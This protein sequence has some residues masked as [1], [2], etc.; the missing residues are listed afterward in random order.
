MRERLKDTRAQEG[1]YTTDRPV[2]LLTLVFRDES[3]KKEFCAAQGLAES[4]T[5]IH[6]E[7]ILDL[8]DLTP[9]QTEAP[10]L[11]IPMFPSELAMWERLKRK[12]KA[13]DD[14]LAIMKIMDQLGIDQS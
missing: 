7:T 9:Y 10:E 2:G 1:D 12:L 4:V 11:V 13:P 14:K 5:T 8:T 3:Q 6:A